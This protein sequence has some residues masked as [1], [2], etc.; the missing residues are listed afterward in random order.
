MAKSVL[1]AGAFLTFTMAVPANA[2]FPLLSGAYL[3]QMNTV[4]QPTLV[5]TTASGA[6][7][8]VSVNTVGH[9]AFSVGT[10]TFT[11]SATAGS[12][13][14]SV[15][16]LTMAGDS[17]LVAT[18]G[19]GTSGTPVASSTTSG[20]SPFTQ[21]ATIFTFI[22]AAGK[23]AYSISYG[24]AV[25]GVAQYAVAVANKLDGDQCA[26]NITLTHK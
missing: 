16:E 17:V 12:G 5:A 11:Q 14:A 19:G 4:C 20:S 6:V 3:A 23:V 8:G 15:S 2:G 7:K 1:V 10:I 21:N 18:R 22:G 25:S 24:P 26:T 9:T 13:T